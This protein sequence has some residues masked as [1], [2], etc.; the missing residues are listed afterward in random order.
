MRLLAIVGVVAV[1]AWTGGGCQRA[2]PIG[3]AGGAPVV[4]DASD[5]MPD[6]GS[7]AGPFSCGVGVTC[8][9]NQYCVPECCGGCFGADGGS[10]P[11]GATACQL[12]GAM[13]CDYC[14]AAH[15]TDTIG[16]CSLG[17]PAEPRRLY[18]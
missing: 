5:G 14:T 8:Q 7:D 4:P 11:A 17:S 9:A 15:C 18:C 13:G 6:Q 2:Y 16:D 1:A 12:N 10:C 3:G